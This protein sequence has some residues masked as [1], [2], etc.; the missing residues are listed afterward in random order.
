M[1]KETLRKYGNI[2]D[3]PYN[4]SK[5]FS[6]MSMQERSAQFSPF[7]AL[8]GHSEI[9]KE[10]AR[11]T[12]CFI[13]LSEGEKQVINN[14]IL[15]LLEYINDH[16]IVSVTYFKNDESKEGGEYLIVH[17]RIKKIKQFETTLEFMEGTIVDI[18]SIYSIDGDIFNK[19][20]ND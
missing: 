16:P 18:R 5:Y 10:T 7:E 13:E 9:I 15:F 6:H 20:Y 17:D 3:L 14:Q 12:N 1:D 19:L 4:K 11:E 2:I 8:T